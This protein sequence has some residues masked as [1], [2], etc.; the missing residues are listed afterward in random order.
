MITNKAILQR[1]IDEVNELTIGDRIDFVQILA[2]LAVAEAINN[3]ADV[4][5]KYGC[6]G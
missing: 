2:I 5:D 4:Q 6:G 1:A 3:L